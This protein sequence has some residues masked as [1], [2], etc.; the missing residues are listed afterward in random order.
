MIMLRPPLPP[1]AKNVNRQAK[2]FRAQTRHG[3][4][5]FLTVRPEHSGRD[6]VH[7]T[8]VHRGG[9]RSISDD[10]YNLHRE[11]GHDPHDPVDECHRHERT[12]SGGRPLLHYL[13]KSW[14]RG[15]LC[16]CGLAGTLVRDRLRVE[17]DGVGWPGVRGEIIVPIFSCI[18]CLL[19]QVYSFNGIFYP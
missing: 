2:S 11:V 10:W 6:P 5:C 13:Q 4:G 12:G 19:L 9:G 3:E 8:A 17:W 15:R 7:P 14:S 1:L 18:F 16:L